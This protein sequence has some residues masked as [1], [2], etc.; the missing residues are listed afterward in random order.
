MV[1][2]L[3]LGNSM[4]NLITIG[5]IVAPHGVR[6]EL[7]IIPQTDY[8]DR[9]MHMDACYIDGKE[10]HV[11]S[12]RAHKQFIL[13]TLQEVTDRDAAEGLA[14]KE[15]QVTRDNLVD[16]PE[17]HYYIFDMIGLAVEDTKGNDLGKV[18]EVLQPG[19]NDVYVVAKDGQ[20]DLLLAAIKSVII[21]IDME[22][23]KMVVDPPEWI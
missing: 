9:F 20:P 7:R 8:P 3:P 2:L 13:L 4:D 12:G 1:K 10:Y 23:G 22:K 18:K 11:K 5:T 21:S 19:A 14:K 16:L 17:G 15:I 6:G